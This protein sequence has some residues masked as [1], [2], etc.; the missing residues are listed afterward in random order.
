MVVKLCSRSHG[1]PRAG[2]RSRAMIASRRPSLSSSLIADRAVSRFVAHAAQADQ[3][4]GV[5]HETVELAGEAVEPFGV[6]EIED[7]L[8]V[9]EDLGDPIVGLFALRLVRG[10]AARLE[11]L[12]ELGIAIMPVIARRLAGEEGLDV[13]VGVDAA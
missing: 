10:E 11:E 7:R 1:Q 9:A 13:R 8:L 2:S 12:V 3:P 4:V 5:R 6:P